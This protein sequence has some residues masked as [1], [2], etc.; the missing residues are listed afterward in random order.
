M[1]LSLV[2]ALPNHGAQNLAVQHAA[3]HS[4]AVH[5]AHHTAGQQPRVAI[6]RLLVRWWG[7]VLRALC[8][9]E[10]VLAGRRCA[11]R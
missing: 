1:V 11:V 8:V 6:G 4:G 5:V 7:S 9:G 3:A 2:D 10:M